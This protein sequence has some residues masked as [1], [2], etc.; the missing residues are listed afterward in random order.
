[1]LFLK[2]RLLKLPAAV[3]YIYMMIVTMLIFGMLYFGT[4][5]GWRKWAFG[6]VG[7]G[8]K[9]MMSK[10]MKKVLLSNLFI[11]I[12]GLVSYLPAARGLVIKGTQKLKSRSKEMYTAVEL[13]KTVI[14][15]LLLVMCI[16]A[17]IVRKM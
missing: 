6:L 1:M 12:V 11:Y 10:Q 7:V 14:K 17:L 3:R 8:D 9:Y 16:A 15:A 2:D 5:Y 13:C 4:V